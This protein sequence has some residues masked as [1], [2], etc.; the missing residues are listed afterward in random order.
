MNQNLNAAALVKSRMTGNCQKI[1]LGMAVVITSGFVGC[2]GGGGEAPP[3]LASVKGK[4]TIN[5]LPA[6][7]LVVTFESQVKGGGRSGALTNAL[8]EYELSYAGTGPSQKGAAIGQHI[9][10]IQSAA[11]TG[12]SSGGTG[13]AGGSPSDLG[14]TDD[15]PKAAGISI[16]E[17][18]N[19][20][21]ELK[22]EVIAGDNPAK[23]FD[24]VIPK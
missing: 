17:K 9:V 21:S 6:A 12:V 23:N 15:S 20:A 1:L 22:T 2:G 18:Y 10:R 14:P 16:P 19:S 8:G 13:A 3:K 4:I 5:G 24:L 11:P 7:D